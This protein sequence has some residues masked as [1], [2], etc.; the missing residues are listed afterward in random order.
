MQ[1][2]VGDTLER[3]SL[4]TMNEASQDFPFSEVMDDVFKHFK[5]SIASGSLEIIV[6][7]DFPSVRANRSR[8]TDIMIGN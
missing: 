1:A 5:D 4:G 3:S 8:V 6:D 7:Q 2:M